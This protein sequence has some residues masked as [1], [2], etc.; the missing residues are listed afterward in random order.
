MMHRLWLIVLLPVLLLALVW[1]FIKYVWSIAFAPEHAWDLAVS[2]D[3]TANAAFNGSEDETISSR[4]GR[5]CRDSHP[6][7]RERWACLLCKLLNKIDNKHCE[8]SIG[9]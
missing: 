3:Q 2:V 1:W 6:E 9:V 4:A 8:K 7:D 5:H